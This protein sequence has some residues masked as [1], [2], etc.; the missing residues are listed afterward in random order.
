MPA[1]PAHLGAAASSGAIYVPASAHAG[2][3]NGA[4]WRTDLQIHNAGASA[5]TATIALLARDSANLSPDTRSVAVAAGGSVRLPDVL[6]GTFG[7]T[8]AAALRVTSTSTRLVVTSRTYNLVGAGAAGLPQGASFGQ[9]VRGVPE[10]TGIAYGEEGRLIQ[11]TQRDASSGL[12][13]R[14]NV[15][16][17]NLGSGTIEV[18]IGLYRADGT[19]LGTRSGEETRLRGFEFRQITEIMKPYGTTADGYAVLRTTTPGGRFLAFATVIDNH[20]SGDPVFMSASKVA[21]VAP[22]PIPTATPTPTPTSGWPNLVIY[23]PSTWPGCVVCNFENNCCPPSTVALSE[24]LP[25]VVMFAIANTGG[26]KLTGAVRFGFS[27]DGDLKTT[28]TW[29]NDSGLDPGYYKSLSTTWPSSVP[30]PYGPHTLTVTADPYFDIAESDETD[31][32]CGFTGDWTAFVLRKPMSRE[33]SRAGKAPPATVREQG[34]AE[35]ISMAVAIPDALPLR[36]AAAGEIWIPAAAHATGV[37]GTNWRT[38]LEVHNPGATA[39]AFTISLLPR[40]ADNSTPAAELAFSLDPQK[41]VRYVDVLDSVFHFTGAAALRI[42]PTTGTVLATSRTY[43]LVG[44]NPSGLPVG[45]SFGQFVPGVAQSEAISS[46]EEGRLIQLTQRDAGSGAD[47]RTNVGI[48]N[49]TAGHVDV[50]LDFFRADGTWLGVKQGSETRLPPYGFRQLTEAFNVWGTT[51]DGYVVARPTTSGGRILAFATVIDNHVTGDPVFIPSE[52]MAASSVP[53]PTPTPTVTPTP[54]GSGTYTEIGRG[55]IGPAGG[56]LSAGGLT[57]S[58]PSGAFGAPATLV[59]TR[60]DAAR[61]AAEP[62]SRY[63]ISDLFGLD[64]LPSDL[65]QPLT[66][67]VPLTSGGP[68]SGNRYVVVGEDVFAPSAAGMIRGPRLL[69]A[70]AVGSNQLRATIP[71]ATGPTGTASNEAA[72]ISSKTGSVSAA[73]IFRPEMT[74]RAVAGISVSTSPTSRFRVFYPASDVVAGGAAGILEALDNASTMLELHLGLSWAKRTRWPIDAEIYPFPADEAER[75]A[76]EQPSRWGVNSHWLAFNASRLQSQS[77]LPNMKVS[78][79]HELFH[80]MQF[81]YDSRN[82]WTQATSPGAWLWLDEASATWFESLMAGSANSVPSEVRADNYVFLK[83]HGLEYPPGEDLK[84]VQN[85]GYGAAMFLRYLSGVR[86]NTAVGDLYKL[87]TEASY[88]SVDAV[89]KVLGTSADLQVAWKRFAESWTESRVYSGVAFPTAA[90]ILSSR[91][92]AYSFATATDTGAEFSWDAPDLSARIFLLRLQYK[93]WPA[94]TELSISLVDS[95]KEAQAVIYRVKSGDASLTR[96]GLIGGGEVFKVPNA[97]VL[98]QE[99]NS[100]VVVVP[101]GRNV[102]PYAGTTPISL[103]VAAGA[104]PPFSQAQISLTSPTGVFRQRTGEESIQTVGFGGPDRPIC[105]GRFTGTTFSCSWNE[106]EDYPYLASTGRISVTFNSK[107]DAV[108]SFAYEEVST[109]TY[110][111]STYTESLEGVGVG[112]VRTEMQPGESWYVFSDGAACSS[113]SKASWS[114]TDIEGTVTMLS[115]A[116]EGARLV[117]EMQE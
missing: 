92:E 1:R 56:T 95:N 41:S 18:Q 117:V 6:L 38:D 29:S 87:H 68:G 82:R 47:F 48:V 74:I 10:E 19:Y 2:G 93:Q 80:L 51:A 106:P 9:F 77:D 3:A 30:I 96:L 102:P 100:L 53:T 58:V 5:T 12:D 94:G 91:N 109:D 43:N 57:I 103:R 61:A 46:T 11:L 84:A 40:D 72:E 39:A 33:G 75:A 23:K 86:G 99:G 31:N 110:R 15:G 27:L 78:A 14:T 115:Y 25:T 89:K 36:V 97:E 67:T 114:V 28:A 22:T 90:E 24:Y 7:F 83:L 88:T 98:A 71:A 111:T 76:Q 59:V 113:L 44:A 79:G 16:F 45:A 21:V 107:Y 42:I 50:R 116:C 65:A 62:Y 69:D 112:G 85:H 63:A 54:G 17:V 108:L 34:R 4:D 55:T 104:A 20:L 105:K 26:T 52:R 49:T 73:G 8:G 32:S 60:G 101:N 13:F 70:T 64:G 37:N 81:L 66:V 35:A